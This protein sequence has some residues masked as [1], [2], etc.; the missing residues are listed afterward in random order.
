V[1]QI[2]ASF[3]VGLLFGAGLLVGGM[4]DANKVIG[5][6]DVS[7]DWDPSLALVMVGAI[8]VHLMFMRLV[9]PRRTAPVLGGRFG[10]PTRT[11]LDGRL[12]GG[13]ALFGLGWGL[14]GFCP[15]PGLVSVASGSATALTFVGAMTGGMALFHAADKALAQ[16]RAPQASRKVA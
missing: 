5:F 14:G 1:K 8:A 15:G 12:L 7:G 4:T 2:A 11:D 9:L 6:L 13:A 10:L 3:G 16:R